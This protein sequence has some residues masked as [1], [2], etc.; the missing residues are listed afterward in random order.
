[1]RF[2]ETTFFQDSFSKIFNQNEI[3]VYYFFANACDIDL[4][5]EF[6][7]FLSTYTMRTLIFLKKTIHVGL[8]ID[9]LQKNLPDDIVI[10]FLPWLGHWSLFPP[11]PSFVFLLALL[12]TDQNENYFTTYNFFLRIFLKIFVFKKIRTD[13]I[14]LITF[15]VMENI[16]KGKIII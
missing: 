2:W 3:I 16:Y 1:M 7:C 11:Y 14:S 12:A 5:F 15:N 13:K 10:L 8:Q 6:Q 9:G 4:S